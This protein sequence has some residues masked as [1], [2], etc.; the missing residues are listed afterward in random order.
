ML[1][2]CR[3]IVSLRVL[4]RKRKKANLS[5][6]SFIIILLSTTFSNLFKTNTKYSNHKQTYRNETTW[7]SNIS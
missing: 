1:F 3:I 7:K 2:I 4:K 6:L 5:I